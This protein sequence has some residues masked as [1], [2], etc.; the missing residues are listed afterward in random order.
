MGQSPMDWTPPKT[1][2]AKNESP[3]DSQSFDYVISLEL[4][5][6][7]S[8]KDRCWEA[9]IPCWPA[10]VEQYHAMSRWIQLVGLLGCYLLRNLYV[11]VFICILMMDVNLRLDI[12]GSQRPIIER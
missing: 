4:L 9:V 10:E 8:V 1:A 5:D 2:V 11:C 12:V 7:L 6:G 3:R